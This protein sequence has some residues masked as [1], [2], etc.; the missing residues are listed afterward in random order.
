MKEKSNLNTQHLKAEKAIYTFVLKYGHSIKNVKQR[1]T[2][3]MP[4]KVFNFHQ[5][6]LDVRYIVS[7][8]LIKGC[9]HAHTPVFICEL[10]ATRS[11]SF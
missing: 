5:K 1:T 3:Q 4:K 7:V 11:I 2:N 8:Q 6:R 10:H 9:V